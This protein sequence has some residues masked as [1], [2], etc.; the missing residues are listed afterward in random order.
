MF[1]CSKRRQKERDIKRKKEEEKIES[2]VYVNQ[3][4]G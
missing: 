3:E 4:W 1:E 2:V